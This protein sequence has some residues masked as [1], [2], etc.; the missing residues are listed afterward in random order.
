MDAL[1]LMIE[2]A[3]EA[4]LLLFGLG[5]VQ[6]GIER[7]F[8][9][10]LRQ[11]LNRALGDRWRAFAAG[12]AATAALQSSTAAGLMIARLQS[13][14]LLALTA[15]LAAML[16]A[17]VGTA[18]IVQ[19]LSFDLRAV[20]PAF[21][22]IG[23]IAFRAR[24]A[25]TRD[26]GR[27]AIGLGL[28][29]AALHLML[30][31]MAPVEDSAALRSLL[32]LLNENP[33]PALLLAAALAWATHSSLAAVLL[34]GSLAA[35]G[36][37][38]P[39]A[40]VAMVAGANLGGAV[41]PLLA[42]RHG[43]RGQADPAA[44]RLPLGNLLNRAVGAVLVLALLGPLS[45]WLGMLDAAPARLVANAH[46]GFN[47]ALAI[48]FL[49]LLDPLAALLRRALP[50]R[51]PE[52][53]PGAPRYLDTAA[54]ATPPVALANAAREVLRLADGVEAMLRA[55]AEALAR[56]DRDAA[57]EVGALDDT[58]D[59]LHRAVHA[60]LAGLP[61]RDRLGEA[62]ARRLA[63]IRHF[64][65]AM[66]HAGDMVDRGLSKH[67]ARRARRGIALSPAEAA[68]LADLHERLVAQLRL[69][70]A[71][72]MLEDAEAARRLVQEK[73]A[74]RDAERQAADHL[75]ETGA[76]PSP[77]AGLA[78]DVTRDLKRIAAHVAAIAYPLLERQGALRT[79]RLRPVQG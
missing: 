63:E 10:A 39:T 68:R 52:A 13:T 7:A 44:M 8:G 28:M 22:L 50:D 42:A 15:A 59:R 9:P 35:A 36:L 31:T 62:E 30:S 37:V 58:V 2:L 26:L 1:R 16:G 70:V 33:L 56:A 21:I 43:R 23:W 73:E 77:A 76:E 6:R 38:G 69:A 79:S 5:L 41:P 60:Y 47:L 45:G 3:G 19:V 65:I 46:L 66:E 17:N 32:P 18:L 4:A 29:L 49:P 25:R 75:A 71:V 24:R 20:F 55:S 14:G 78:L 34:V 40:A 48:L 61:P 64:A 54:L 12:L 57:R 51:A 74:W 11:G 67:A 27:A 53:D 72:F